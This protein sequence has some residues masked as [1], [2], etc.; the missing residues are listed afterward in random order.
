MTTYAVKVERKVVERG[1]VLIEAATTEQAEACAQWMVERSLKFGIAGQWEGIY[2]EK[3]AGEPEVDTD[4]TVVTEDE[5]L[6]RATGRGGETIRTEHGERLRQ[7]YQ[8]EDLDRLRNEA[9]NLE[10]FIE[11]QQGQRKATEETTEETEADSEMDADSESPCNPN[12][13]PESP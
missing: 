1:T 10:R 8:Q 5:A 4:A 9:Q 11:R 6:W 12:D 13:N 2:W 7:R 3:E